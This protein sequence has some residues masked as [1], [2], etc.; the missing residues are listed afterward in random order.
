ME[1][2]S[3]ALIIVAG[4]TFEQYSSK[5]IAAIREQTDRNIRKVRA[6]KFKK[7]RKKL[8]A[9]LQE[10]AGNGQPLTLSEKEF[11]ADYEKTVENRKRK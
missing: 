1:L 9:A 4:Q 10:K 2:L 3:P 11:L 7:I 8:F 5:K 6:T